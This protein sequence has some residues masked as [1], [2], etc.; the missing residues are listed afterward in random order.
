MTFR[1]GSLRLSIPADA[2]ASDDVVASEGLATYG[3]R[4]KKLFL[5]K[6][7]SAAPILQFSAT[8]SMEWFPSLMGGSNNHQTYSDALWTMAKTILSMFD[9]RTDMC[10]FTSAEVKVKAKPMLAFPI[11]IAGDAVL[12]APGFSWD[13]F[14]PN[15]DKLVEHHN[16]YALSLFRALFRALFR[17]LFRSLFLSRSLCAIFPPSVVLRL[18]DIVWR[19]IAGV[20]II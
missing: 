6:A 15:G 10:T 13:C 9:E 18:T 5:T 12:N 14:G 20:C 11:V 3:E 4:Y 1:C 19:F 16:R 8:M 2:R 17:S 7:G